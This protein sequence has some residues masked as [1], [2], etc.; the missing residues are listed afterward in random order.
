MLVALRISE[1]SKSKIKGAD[2]M[3]ELKEAK[4]KVDKEL[5]EIRMKLEGK[6]RELE[7]GRVAAV[8]GKL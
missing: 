5:I 6:E 7:E 2:E 1:E 4:Q 8:E 3:K